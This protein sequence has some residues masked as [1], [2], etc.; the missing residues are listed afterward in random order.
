MH[1]SLLPEYLR[2]RAA[3]S[4]HDVEFDEIP[5]LFRNLASFG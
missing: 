3:S 1:S 4:H 5:F 2:S